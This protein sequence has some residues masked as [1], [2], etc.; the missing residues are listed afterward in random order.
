MH[1]KT[2][3]QMD[4][5][6]DLKS[7]GVEVFLSNGCTSGGIQHSKTLLVDEMFALI[8][9]TNWINSSRSNHEMSVLVELN[10][11]GYQQA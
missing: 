10:L 2:N 4:C 5:L 7:Q 6:K 1:G 8:G 9:S 3:D 11:G